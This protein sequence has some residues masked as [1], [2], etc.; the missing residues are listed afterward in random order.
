MEEEHEALNRSPSCSH[1]PEGPAT[2]WLT[3]GLGLAHFCAKHGLLMPGYT[4]PMGRKS[5]VKTRAELSREERGTNDAH[6]RELAQRKLKQQIR[7][8]KQNEVNYYFRAQEMNHG[9]PLTQ[10]AA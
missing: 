10:N 4:R 8:R 3:F 6:L 7:Q 1:K 5:R 2:L 9:F